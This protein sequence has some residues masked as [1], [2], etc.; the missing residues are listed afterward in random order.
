MRHK[1]QFVI[2]CILLAVFS[3]PSLAQDRK[4]DLAKMLSDRDKNQ[5]GTLEPDE[6]SDRDKKFL[7]GMN[8]STS[9]SIVI[10]DVVRKS[11]ADRKQA[12]KEKADKE[13]NSINWDVPGFGEPVESG[14]LPGFGDVGEDDSES[15]TIPDFEIKEQSRKESMI[16]IREQFG[17]RI[18]DRVEGIFKSYDKNKDG[19]LDTNEVKDIPWRNPPWKEFDENND[20]QM[21]KLELAKRYKAGEEDS[22]D[23]KN[24][25][26]RNRNNGGDRSKSGDDNRSSDSGDRNKSK[27]S[28]SKGKSSVLSLIHI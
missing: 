8:I 14:E 17:R 2:S 12:A 25:S 16:S 13:F 19:I 15:A 20:G 11:Q 24:N 10:A 28:S 4:F 18:N 23:N 27:N 5:S 9:G 26:R 1:I 21:S 3:I 6:L 22:S 7:Q